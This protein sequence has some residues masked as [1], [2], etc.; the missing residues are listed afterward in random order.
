MFLAVSCAQPPPEEARTPTQAHQKLIKLCKEEYNL[1]VVTKAF[2]NTIWIYLPLDKSYLYLTASKEGPMKSSESEEK[3]ALKYVDGEF[4]DNTF[5]LGYD[6]SKNKQY[7]DS[8]GIGTKT[9]EEY[10]AKQQFLFSA[11]N[12]AYGDVEKLPDSDEYVEGVPG[13]VTY[14][15]ASVNDS[16]KRL[17]R[18]YIKTDKVPDFFVIV[19]ADI[20]KGIE[21][22]S[23]LY[24]QDLRRV[25]TDQGFG[26][27]YIRRAVTDQPI[28]HEVIIGDKAGSHLNAYDMTWPEFLMKQMVYRT[29]LK[30]TFSSIPPYPDTLQQ[31]TEI[32][33]E[34]IRGYE[35]NDFSFV[36]LVDLRAGTMHMLTKTELETVEIAPPALPGKIHH[37]KFN[38]GPPEENKE[39]Y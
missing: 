12:R 24:L 30:Y 14:M 9:T 29:T 1:D 33:A 35:F 13:D 39:N 18:S 15:G 28:G 26:E 20:E 31:L 23:Y 11:I 22:R 17:V 16:H 25:Y 19:I 34:T 5:R 32:A 4:K 6:I 8:K 2:E 7:T 10:T 37:I 36:H 3:M 27:E 38:I 21:T